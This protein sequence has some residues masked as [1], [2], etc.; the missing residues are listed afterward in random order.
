MKLD[1]ID[2]KILTTLQRE[3]RITK[4]KLAEAVSL[5]ASACLERVKKLEDH[6][7]IKGY[8]ADVAMEKLV[9]YSAILVEITLKNHRIEDFKVFEA[10]IN[11]IPEIVECYAVGGGIDYVVKFVTRS[12][13][14]Y[15]DIMDGL[16]TDD[17]GIDK[18]F[19]YFITKLTKK[20]PYPLMKFADLDAAE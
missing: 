18:Y 4:Q 6:G 19:S 11:D 3:G 13:E 2:L 12:I 17:V 16:L 20:S 15:Q 7:Y 8:Y 14:H 9:P 1:R 10:A 5:S